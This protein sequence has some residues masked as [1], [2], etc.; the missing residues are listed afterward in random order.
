MFIIRA[1][2]ILLIHVFHVHADSCLEE[3]HDL[4]KIVEENTGMIR[5][6]RD[7]VNIQ[8][9][10]IQ[11]LETRLAKSEDEKLNL[12]LTTAHISSGLVSLLLEGLMFVIL[13]FWTVRFRFHFPK[14]NKTR[15]SRNHSFFF[16]YASPC[17]LSMPRAPRKETC[18]GRLTV[19][20]KHVETVL[21][22]THYWKI[23]V[24]E[25]LKTSLQEIILRWSW[26][27]VPVLNLF[28]TLVLGITVNK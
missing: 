12:F 26:K 3:I 14:Q 8:E 6:F 2:P 9:R 7:T 20:C 27:Y 5:A 17:S 4:R 24:F 18:A 21:I 28:K 23:K 16:S 11:Q 25:S 10:R 13:L 1:I 19:M 22:Q 15:C